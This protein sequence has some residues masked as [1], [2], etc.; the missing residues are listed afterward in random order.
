MR[1][2]ELARLKAVYDS[3]LTGAVPNLGFLYQEGVSMKL[4]YIEDRWWC[5]FEPMTFVDVPREIGDETAPQNKDEFRYSVAGKG[6]PAGEWRRERWARKYNK[7]WSQIIGAWTTLLT[8]S[9]DGQVSAFDL[10]EDEGI[11]AV[12]SLSPIT[13]WSRPSHHH[14][15]FDRTK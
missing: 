5:C 1:E 12:F 2:S 15:Y 10:K 6:D 9:K 8:S 14:S 13:G 3:N 4:E 7:Q 11:D